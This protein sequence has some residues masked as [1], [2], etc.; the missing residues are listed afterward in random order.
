MFLTTEPGIPGRKYNPVKVISGMATRASI[1]FSNSQGY[2]S[3][4]EEALG[5][6]ERNAGKLQ[7]D[8]VVAIQLST[9]LTGGGGLLVTVLGTAIKFQ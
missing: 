8:G 3:A 5:E 7:A 9:S 6:L 4:V 1:G 2:R